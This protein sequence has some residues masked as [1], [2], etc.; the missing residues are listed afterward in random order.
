MTR[1][2]ILCGLNE[3][4]GSVLDCD[5][6]LTEQASAKEVEGWDSLNHVRIMMA[7][8][9]KFGVRFTAT[10]ITSLSDVGALISLIASKSP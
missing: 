3:V 10:D 1:T 4:V 7:V 8:E 2:D 6:S 5:V 9:K